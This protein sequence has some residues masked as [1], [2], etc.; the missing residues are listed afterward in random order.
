VRTWLAEQTPQ[1]QAGVE[2]VMIDPSAPYASGIR[3][4]LPHARIAVDHRHLVR[5]AHGMLT[6]VRR[7][8]TRSAT[9]AAGSPLT[10]YGCTGG[11]CSAPAT[12]CPN[13]N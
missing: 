1:F 2:L 5:L 6:Q 10:S 7:R 8:V 12:G 13:D 11:C 9:A 3:T 4:A